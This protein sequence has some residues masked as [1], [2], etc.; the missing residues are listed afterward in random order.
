M[1]IVEDSEGIC[2]RLAG[3]PPSTLLE[4][5]SPTDTPEPDMMEE[6]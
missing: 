1:G 5:P 6:N 2:A 3:N 4:T